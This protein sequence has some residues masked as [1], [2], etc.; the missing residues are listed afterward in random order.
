MGSLQR[1]YVY[2]RSSKILWRILTVKK[3]YPE[4]NFYNI[5]HFFLFFFLLLVPGFHAPTPG[6]EGRAEAPVVV[7]T[8]SHPRP[9][10]G[11][12]S[13]GAVLAGGHRY[14]TGTGALELKY[15][16]FWCKKFG[17]SK[18]SV[19]TVSYST[20]FWRPLHTCSTFLTPILHVNNSQLLFLIY[21]YRMKKPWKVM[22]LVQ[23][24]DH[25]NP[26]YHITAS[27]QHFLISVP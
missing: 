16:S 13:G 3:L 19:F 8:K 21:K 9:R 11:R 6:S 23:S 18:D 1:C 27:K 20:N 22:W 17:D 25:L 15:C 14:L 7:G 4:L 12:F 10:P 24:L 2:K 26:L 5:V